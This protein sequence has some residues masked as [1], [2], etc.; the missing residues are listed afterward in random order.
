VINRRQIIISSCGNG[1]ELELVEVI[2]RDNAVMKFAL[3]K[4]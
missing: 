1:F 3:I 2:K 4:R